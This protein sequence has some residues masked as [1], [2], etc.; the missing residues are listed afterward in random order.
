MLLEITIKQWSTIDKTSYINTVVLYDFQVF[1][2]KNVLN[3]NIQKQNNR[4]S[5]I[6]LNHIN[7]IKMRKFHK[8]MVLISPE[9]FFSIAKFMKC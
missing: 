7:F 5:N 4:N 9:I 3:A 2:K 6:V 1:E 8:L